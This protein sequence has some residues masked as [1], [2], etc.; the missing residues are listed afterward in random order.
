[1]SRII[2]AGFKG[3]SGSATHFVEMAG[4]LKKVMPYG[5]LVVEYDMVE[6]GPRE[7]IKTKESDILILFKPVPY[8]RAGYII[9]W[10]IFETACPPRKMIRWLADSSEI[11]VPSEWGRSVLIAHGITPSKVMVVNE[12]VNPF[13][14]NRLGKVARE[15]VPIKLLCVATL[16]VRKG[17]SDVVDAFLAAQL[18]PSEVELVLQ[19]GQSGR[20]DF[21]GYY[22]SDDLLRKVAN[23]DNIKIRQ[24][25]IRSD[26]MGV[27]YRSHHAFICGSRGEGWG[28][29]V[30]EAAAAGLPII[31]PV[32]TGLGEFLSDVRSN[33]YSVA[34]SKESFD[35]TCLYSEDW[36][37]EDSSNTD[38]WHPVN[39]LELSE[40]IVS[41]VNDIKSGRA[42]RAG[43]MV[44]D[45]L[46]KNFS[47]DMAASA[48]WSHI[49]ERP[50][51]GL[52]FSL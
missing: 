43:E 38:Y 16:H 24:Q 14:Y 49:L 11:W 32:H 51:A 9:K 31:S 45:R 20:Y 41:C 13:I 28:L 2:V 35:H 6:M 4:A 23:T 3:R 21:P 22:S 30:I 42:E 50:L 40:K 12:G 48:A 44:S 29:P 36:I 25:S 47:W 37:D 39:K 10:A 34:F 19:V 46:R 26:S 15:P 33:I 1:M 7:A 18:D 52:Q 17:L 27:F 8:V 5:R